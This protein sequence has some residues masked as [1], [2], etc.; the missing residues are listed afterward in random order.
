[1]CLKWVNMLQEENECFSTVCS[2]IQIHHHPPFISISS[3]P[4]VSPIP[5][6]H[7]IVYTV[8]LVRSPRVSANA[9]FIIF[10][11]IFIWSAWVA[12]SVKHLPLAQLMIS[13]SWDRAPHQALCSARS[14]LLPLPLSLPF[15]LLVLFYRNSQ[16]FQLPSPLSTAK[17]SASLHLRCHSTSQAYPFSVTT[18][19]LAHLN[20]HWPLEL[21]N[22]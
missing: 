3:I 22:S 8:T 17:I 12:Q 18:H 14:L 15:P 4:L 21:S 9:W 19:F 2:R 11:L 7:S 10:F 16:V 1:M 5:I 6:N 13:G 20:Q